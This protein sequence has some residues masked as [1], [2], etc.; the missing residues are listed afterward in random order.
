LRLHAV[1]A[2]ADNNLGMLGIA[3]IATKYTVAAFPADPIALLPQWRDARR[4]G[5]RAP[6]VALARLAR[7]AAG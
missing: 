2:L 6:R 7:R 5:Y 4:N 3:D 1:N